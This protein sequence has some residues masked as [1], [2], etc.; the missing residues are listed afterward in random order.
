MPITDPRP[1]PLDTYRLF[2]STDLDEAREMVARTFCDHRL[3]QVR[4]GDR[5][6]A[7]HNHVAGN[8]FSLNYIRYGADVEIEP[9]ELGSFYLIQIPIR[10]AATIRHGRRE[11]L[12]TPERASVLNP[13]RHTTMRWHA[14]C[15]KIL[16]QID[17]QA[18]T[19]L[20]ETLSGHTLA[21]PVRFDPEIDFSRPALAAWA[22]RVRALVAAADDAATLPGVADPF[23]RLLEE[24]LLGR[25]VALQPGNAAHFLDGQPGA[26]QPRSV[27]RALAYIRDNLDG[28]IALADL[29]TAAGVSGR[30]VQLG[31]QAAFGMSPL[32][33]ARAERLKQVHFALLSR[34]DDT[35]IADLAAGWG[36]GHLGRFSA[37]YR[38]TFGCLPSET[39]PLH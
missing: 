1:A 27:K 23:R 8:C 9:G 17:R 38:R 3:S 37:L 34:A 4:S 21:G 26:I 31:F 5:F 2:E 13:D 22:R 6:D 10:G 25:F 24:E 28:P 20:V 36:F 33:V 7:R 12:A 35:P 18:L 14:G 15:E 30:T 11:V 16:L 39:R 32:Q 29:A 19:R